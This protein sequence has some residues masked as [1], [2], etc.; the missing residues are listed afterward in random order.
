V[1]AGDALPEIG[2]GEGFSRA[3][4]LEGLA[5]PLLV[6]VVVRPIA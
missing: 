3:F 2:D 6:R 4:V 5:P 1:T